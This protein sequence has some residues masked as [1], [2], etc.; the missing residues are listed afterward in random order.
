MFR[1]LLAP[2]ALV[3]LV[4]SPALAQRPPRPAQRPS[5]PTQR[6]ATP[7]PCA[8]ATPECTEWITVGGGPGRSLVYR[9]FA[10][11]TRNEAITRAVIVV[12]GAGRDADNY[13]RSALAGAFLAGAL[14]TA[15]VVAPRQAS[16]AR[17]GCRDSLAQDEISWDCDTWRSGGPAVS[18]PAVTSF[19]LL[20][21]ILRKL[22]RRDVFP[23]LEGIVV[24]GHSAGG[25][26]TNR[27][28]M[29]SKVSDGLAVPVRFVVAN[30]SSYA[31]PTDE[32]PTG[33]L[34]W[35][36]QAGA[37]GF[38]PAVPPDAP[39]FR[40]LREGRGC[41][42]YDIWPYG[43]KGRTGYV[44]ALGD[45]Q[46]T[47]QL[48]ARA[49]TYLLG[50]DDVLPLSGFD[51]SCAAMAQGPTRR[52]RGEAYAKYVNERLGGHHDVVVVTGCG[53]NGRCI[54][55]SEPWLRI[56]FPRP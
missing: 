11:D 1:R 33:P 48:A 17:P 4:H 34:A 24:T 12:H 16:K 53:H 47:R 45:S 23:N 28:G 50:E 38:V 56:A 40:S 44:A 9:S 29:S 30:P 3:A 46:L 52:A 51:G 2:L 35:S 5:G 43:F 32:R 54:Y 20:D 21:E 41:T 39:A 14:Q 15:I 8:T 13:Y 18:H 10:L 22:A 26:V 37:P 49:V 6:P 36:L 55:T 27:Y 31:W 42:V 7:A 19:D 25:Q